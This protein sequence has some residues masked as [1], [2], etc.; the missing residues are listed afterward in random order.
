MVCSNATICTYV[1]AW[2][3]FRTR[4]VYVIPIHY[5]IICN[6]SGQITTPNFF[7]DSIP[8]TPLNFNIPA[9]VSHTDNYTP[10]DTTVLLAEFQHQLHYSEAA[11][12]QAFRMRKQ[13]FD[14]KDRCLS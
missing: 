4:A 7:P 12:N 14:L 3:D 2:S 5:T 11:F 8:N 13:T 1:H 6:G 10:F 9:S